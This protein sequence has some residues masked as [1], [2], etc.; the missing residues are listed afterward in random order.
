MSAR[1][2]SSAVGSSA[3]LRRREPLVVG[4]AAEASAFFCAATGGVTPGSE[5]YES[6]WSHA[7][8]SDFAVDPATPTPT[9]TRPSRLQR[10]A[11]GT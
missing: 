5:S 1:R 9:T 4:A 8:A 11:S 7:A 6:N 10:C 3:F 2:S